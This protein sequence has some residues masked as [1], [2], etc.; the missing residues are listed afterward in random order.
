L[1]LARKREDDILVKKMVF[2]ELTSGI[3]SFSHPYELEQYITGLDSKMVEELLELYAEAS[4]SDLCDAIKHV[5]ELLSTSVEVLVPDICL[6]NQE[7][8]TR[9]G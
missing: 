5:R 4:P 9:A 3:A 8:Q 7:R 2:T 1:K 6:E